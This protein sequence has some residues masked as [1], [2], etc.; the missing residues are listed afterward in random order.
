M[1]SAVRFTCWLLC[2][3]GRVPDTCRVGPREEG[4]KEENLLF[5]PEIEPRLL[6][7]PTRSPV[8][9]PAILHRLCAG[10]SASL[11]CI[12]GEQFLDQ[13]ACQIVNKIIELRHSDVSFCYYGNNSSLL[14]A[15]ATQVHGC[16]QPT[17]RAKYVLSPVVP[18]T[19]TKFYTIGHEI[20]ASW[21]HEYCLLRVR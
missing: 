9:A 13:G 4:L 16:T 21:H 6:G 14:C 20:P 12:K 2:I 19:V 17:G 3:Q 18:L 8:T 15:Q 1:R 10:R 11:R 5:Q 7:C